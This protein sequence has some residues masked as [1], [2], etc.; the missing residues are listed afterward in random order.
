MK[1][2]KW[3]NRCLLL[4]FTKKLV[5]PPSQVVLRVRRL[6]RLQKVVQDPSNHVQ[7]LSSLYAE[8]DREKAFFFS[9]WFPVDDGTTVRE[10][11]GGRCAGTIIF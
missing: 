4:R 2:G 8:M 9:Q 7:L 1:M 11:V 5:C 3:S 6:K 10:A